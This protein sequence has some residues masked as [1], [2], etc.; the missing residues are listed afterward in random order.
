MSGL[1]GT[2]LVCQMVEET[3]EELIGQTTGWRHHLLTV[4]VTP[5][6]ALLAL[7]TQG[8]EDV[9][10]AVVTLGWHVGLLEPVSDG[11]C[12]DP[13]SCSWCPG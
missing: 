13:G 9:L 3:L 4:C 12:H 10:L 7:E 5:E 11:V 8:R 1:T 6:L 2:V